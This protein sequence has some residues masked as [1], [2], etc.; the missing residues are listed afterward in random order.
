MD[1]GIK[2]MENTL[3]D[4][5]HSNGLRNTNPSFKV[6]F[7]LLTMVVCVVSISPVVP[8]IITVLI[9]FLIVFKAKIPYKFYLKFITIPFLFGFMTFIF[10][11]LFFGMID[12][13]FKIDLINLTVYKDGFNLG[14][15]VLARILG[16]FSCLAFLALTTP[17]TEI[18]SLLEEFKIPVVVLE[19]A[20]LMYRYIFV[21]LEEAANMYNSQ[22]TRL[23][24]LSIRGSFKSLG[25]LASNLFIRTWVRGEQVY[26]SM[27]SRCYDGSMKTFKAH[28]SIGT[29][30]MAMLVSFEFLLILGTYF[31]AS[32]KMI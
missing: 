31:T 4:Y 25:I 21:F 26:I 23:G 3:D 16:G 5:A 2:K 8:I 27:E 13:W 17:M 32:F 14:V 22:K 11:A 1:L 6:L 15:L 18:F 30:N 29:K 24:Y 19:I 9:F 10:M 28:N 12:P 20:M 7:A